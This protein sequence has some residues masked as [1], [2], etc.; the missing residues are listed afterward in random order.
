MGSR[1]VDSIAY[2]SSRDTLPPIQV[3]DAGCWAKHSLASSWGHLSMSHT[4]V[5]AS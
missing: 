5:A 4:S 2:L 1:Q 3:A